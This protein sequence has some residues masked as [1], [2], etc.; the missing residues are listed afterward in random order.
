M[1]LV[2]ERVLLKLSGESLRGAQ[3]ASPYCDASMQVLAR[4]IQCAVKEGVGL[5]IVMG[6]GNVFRGAQGQSAWLHRHTADSIGMMA[7]MMN[8][9]ALRS[10]LDHVGVQCW[11]SSSIALH[12]I[13]PAF[14]PEAMNAALAR[15]DVLLFSG[16]TG[17]PYVST[18]TASAFR[19]QQMGATV[20]LKATQV[21]GVYTAD[22][23]VDAT[24]ERMHQLTYEEVL[25]KDLR[26]MD[27]TS[28][29]FCREY[30]IPILVGKLGQ[31][32]DALVRVARGERIGTLVC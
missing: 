7:T 20:L 12:G 4:Q 1:S 15:G 10:L 26:V 6:G 17:H 25:S 18:D 24:A 28:I 9:L 5:G 11:L 8:G 31:A 22:P 14:D 32:E 29:S 30:K 2:Y 27:A 16:G 19:A 3:Q 23:K 13:V 21:D